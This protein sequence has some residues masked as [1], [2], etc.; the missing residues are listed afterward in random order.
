[1]EYV[2][3]STLPVGQSGSI[4]PASHLVLAASL[5]SSDLSPGVACPRVCTRARLSLPP[6]QVESCQ[7]R[8]PSFSWELSHRGEE[9]ERRPYRKRKEEQ[10]DAGREW[11]YK[12]SVL[13]GEQHCV[14]G[15]AGGHSAVKAAVFL[16]GGSTVILLHLITDLEVINC[17]YYCMHSASIY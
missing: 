17:G 4:T 13:T 11:N 2:W 12:M 6:S 9:E 16:G 5:L 15:C 3:F 14:L 1:M 7:W 8:E 10:D